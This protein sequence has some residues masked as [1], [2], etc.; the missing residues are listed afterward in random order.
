M[1]RFFQYLGSD[2]LIRAEFAVNIVLSDEG[3]VLKKLVQ[4]KKRFLFRK[5]KQK[6]FVCKSQGRYRSSVSQF[7][8]ILH[9]LLV[10]SY[11]FFKQDSAHLAFLLDIFISIFGNISVNESDPIGPIIRRR[12]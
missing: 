1:H 10:I 3:R 8:R 11:F 2:T 9:F 4:H 6:S 7:C 5:R 12:L